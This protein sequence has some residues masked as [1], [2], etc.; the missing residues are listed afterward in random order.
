M[1]RFFKVG[2]VLAVF[3][4]TG[5]GIKHPQTAEEFRLGA[6]TAFMGTK[7]SYEVNRS[8]EQVATGWRA[9]APQCLDVRVRTESSTT[10]R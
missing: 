9:M 7:E 10:T 1:N 4:L 6:P 8:L 2:G 5:C 3:L